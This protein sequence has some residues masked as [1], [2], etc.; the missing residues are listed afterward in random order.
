M[1][2]R[3]LRSRRRSVGSRIGISVT[4][5]AVPATPQTL[6]VITLDILT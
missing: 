6:I 4:K 3:P 5:T 2:D 1:E